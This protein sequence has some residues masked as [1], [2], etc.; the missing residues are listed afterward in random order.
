[1]IK[2]RKKIIPVAYLLLITSQFLH[3]INLPTYKQNNTVYSLNEP[4]TP[5]TTHQNNST[6]SAPKYIPE[7]ITPVL[8]SAPATPTTTIL[9]SATSTA[10]Y[11][12][13]STTSTPTITPTY[14]PTSTLTP[15]STPTPT[16]TPLSSATVQPTNTPENYNVTIEGWFKG[17]RNEA[18]N[19]FKIDVYEGY[20][21]NPVVETATNPKGYFK[22]SFNTNTKYTLKVYKPDSKYMP[23]VYRLSLIG[24]FS[25]GSLSKPEVI[26]WGDLNNDEIVNIADIIVVSSNFGRT[27]SST[28]YNKDADLNSDGVIN[29]NDIMKLSNI[30]SATPENQTKAIYLESDAETCY[31]PS[32]WYS[33]E[34]T[35]LDL[36]GYRLYINGS[37]VFKSSTLINS[38][39][40]SL[41]IN[42][43][44]L[45][46]LNDLNFGQPGYNDSLI[47]TK[48]E[49]KLIVGK[50]F[51]FAT[52]V[53]HEGILTAGTIVIK[54]DYFNVNDDS[55]NKAF[56]CT[57]NHKIQLSG[58]H[59]KVIKLSSD[60]PLR[61]RRANII[62]VPNNYEFEIWPR[63]AYNSITNLP[64]DAI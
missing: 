28:S 5:A 51:I 52:A 58:S 1:M 15:T 7:N 64:A 33:M 45:E 37:L 60:D 4:A 44:T 8:A 17:D 6:T 32:G 34:D 14:I 25:I 39:G 2:L 42:G 40:S 56:Y 35:S 61:N 18:R 22:L 36:K 13:T 54:G 20:N 3:P 47:M 41:N 49:G 50:G 57:K 11:T 10:V 55:N 48:E 23:K 46:I 31:E 24:N 59:K 38:S 26:H 62:I 63:N 19:D 53:D 43:G 21:S 29:M 16:F 30:F 12:A 9:S 27:S